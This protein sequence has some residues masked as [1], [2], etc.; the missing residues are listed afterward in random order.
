M[1]RNKSGYLRRRFLTTAA[2]VVVAGISIAG[3]SAQGGS[4]SSPVSASNSPVSTSNTTQ[5]Q[6]V[7]DSASKAI[8]AWAGPTEGP[9]AAVGKTIGIISC[10]QGAE[11][12][13]REAVG[14]KEA[15][16]ALGWKVISIDGQGDPQ[17]QLAGMNSLL[18]QGVSAIVIGSINAASIGDGMQRAKSLHV[19]VIAIVSPD[20][21]EFGGLTSVGPDDKAAG[22]VLAAYVTTQ[23]G[24]KVAVFDHTENPAVADRGKGFRDSL[25]SYGGSDVIYN[26]AVTL[27]QIGPPEQQIMSA[28]L[29]AHPAGSVDWVYAGFDAMLTP[30]I[31]S[32]DRAGRNELKAVSID[33]NLENL[34]FIRSGK[35]EVATVGYPLEW[36]GW[37]AV[38]DLNRVFAGQQIVDQKIPFRFFTKDNLPAAGKAFEGDFD[39]R[40]AY[41]KLWHR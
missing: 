17:R 19:P 30:L 3:C 40:A 37:G 29:Q 35:I 6:Q 25:K 36:A 39:F 22:E 27:S 32:A 1:Q 20:P 41:K 38:D 4:G 14:A 10:A 18:D 23:G 24:G 12:C 33:G 21:K 2:I 34:S 9:A 16:Q 5:A 11:G 26:Q 28:F 13:V 7:I 8:T 15:A 31:Q